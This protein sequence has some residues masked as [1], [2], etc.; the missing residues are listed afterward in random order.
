MK[1]R[2][3]NISRT[4]PDDIHVEIYDGVRT[5][6]PGVYEV[7]YILSRNLNGTNHSGIAKLIVIVE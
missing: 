1:K 7:T 5:D 6:L 3:I 4:I 2:I